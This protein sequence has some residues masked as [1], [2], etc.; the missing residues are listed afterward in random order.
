MA[1]GAARLRGPWGERRSRSS[2][3]AS[4]LSLIPL[5]PVGSEGTLTEA[6]SFLFE[7]SPPTGGDGRERGGSPPAR[8]DN[9]NH[10]PGIA[11]A[12]GQACFVHIFQDFDGHVAA[13]ARA[14]AELFSGE[15][16]I[17][18]GRRQRFGDGH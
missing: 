5:P 11:F 3:Q 14:V 9:L 13:D 12:A 15:A 18:I 4:P 10:L 7:P 17:R 16:L 8:N 6:A 2:L 1:V